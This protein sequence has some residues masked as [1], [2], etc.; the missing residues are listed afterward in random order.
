MVARGD[1]ASKRLLIIGGSIM[2]G[3]SVGA[4]ALTSQLAGSFALALV[5]MAATGVFNTLANT[6]SQSTLQLMTTDHIRGRVMGFYGMTY[7][8]RPLGAAQAGALAALITAPLA[9][10]A[11]ALAVVVFSMGAPLFS[12]KVRDLDNVLHQAE[13][14]PV[15]ASQNT[16][17][18][19]TTAND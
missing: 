7:N 4:F 3:I 8:I 15:A 17:R 16:G 2:S 12:R 19:P 9:I 6:A 10:A 1:T 5:L 13:P 14:V 18:S 11:G